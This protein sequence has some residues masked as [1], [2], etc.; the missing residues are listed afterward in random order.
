ML[1]AP[2]IGAAR[3]AR[4]WFLW[5]LHPDCGTTQ[6]VDLRKVDRHRDTAIS[7]RCHAE[8]AARIRRSPSSCGC[9][10]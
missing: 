2:T 3:A 9:H 6:A 8:H 7:P 10:Q 5:V 1:F 4:Y